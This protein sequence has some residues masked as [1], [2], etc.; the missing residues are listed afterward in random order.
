MRPVFAVLLSV[1]VLT[2]PAAA[3]R[4]AP[5]PAP[6][7]AQAPG[8]ILRHLIHGPL[9]Q[10]APSHT[11]GIAQPVKLMD[12]SR[13]LMWNGNFFLRGTDGHWRP[14]PPGT[15]LA[16]KRFNLTVGAKGGL[17][18]PMLRRVTLPVTV[19]QQVV[20]NGP[21]MIAVHGTGFP[22]TLKLHPLFPMLQV[23]QPQNTALE[24]YSK[25][26]PI[27]TNGEFQSTGVW[28]NG[29]TYGGGGMLAEFKWTTDPSRVT[30]AV[31]QIS[32]KAFPTT[33]A[34]NTNWDMPFSGLRASIVVPGPVGA[35]NRFEI[36]LHSIADFDDPEHPKLFVARLVPLD[37]NGNL[38]GA[39][40]APV[41]LVTP[42]VPPLNL[43]PGKPV[44]KSYQP[45]LTAQSWTPAQ[46]VANADDFTGPPAQPSD[47]DTTV[48]VPAVV[49][50][51]GF[52]AY[53]QLSVD[54]AALKGGLGIVPAGTRIHLDWSPPDEG[55]SGW[56]A[57]ADFVSQ[58]GDYITGAINWVSHSF[59]AIKNVAVSAV[60]DAIE[61][62]GVPPA[63]ANAV[64]DAIV[65]TAM[66]SCGIPPSLPDMDQ[67][68]NAGIDYVTDLAADQ[69]G[70]SGIV[71]AAH[72]AI[73]SDQIR[74][75]INK[76]VA[77]VKSAQAGGGDPANWFT[78]DPAILYHPPVLFVRAAY[79]PGAGDP[80]QSDSDDVIVEVYGELPSDST[81]YQ[82]AEQNGARDNLPLWTGRAHIPPMR[83]GESYIVPIVLDFSFNHP[84]ITGTPVSKDDWSST[85]PLV[86]SGRFSIDDNKVDNTINQAW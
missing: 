14:A 25:P 19:E 79:N 31:L 23:V 80:Q 41:Y 75:G 30:Q 17:L 68:E 49:V 26:G 13:G 27:V 62:V 12:G 24:V 43:P 67:L 81:G 45:K 1:T 37:V 8:P 57:F 50:A 65:D 64:G 2:L 69:I 66:V 6:P 7:P 21:H 32:T 18:N 78:P 60:A 76:T 47:I 16:R 55:T 56:D 72:S 71:D 40:T 9:Q 33:A 84:D 46:N 5:P 11:T 54:G 10:P 82:T 38:A 63:I 28:G 44:P 22:S 53:V 29:G 48:P 85:Y 4:A 36:G 35:T 52:P 58:L 70:A 20:H 83:A 61:V 51:N 59:A 39:P 15:Y 3:Q 74:Q 77:T 42:Y 86:V 73:S 34:T